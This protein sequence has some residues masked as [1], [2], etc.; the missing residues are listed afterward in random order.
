MHIFNSYK[1]RWLAFIL[2]FNTHKI[3]TLNT[4]LSFFNKLSQQKKKKRHNKNDRKIKTK[5]KLKNP[6]YLKLQ[7]IKGKIMIKKT[8]LWLKITIFAI[9]AITP[10][11]INTSARSDSQQNQVQ[12]LAARPKREVSTP[13]I[14]KVGLW[15]LAFGTNIVDGIDG[16]NG[17]IFQAQ[18][19]DLYAMGYNTGLQVLKGGKLTDGNEF[20]TA[21]GTNI[22]KGQYGTIFQAQNGDLY[23]MGYGTGLQVLKGGGLTPG[24]AFEKALGTNIIKGQYGTIFQARNGDLYAMGWDTELQVLKGG[25]LTPRKAFEKALG[26]NITKGQYGTIFQA[27]NGDLYAMGY[28]TG[29]EVLKGGKLTGGN[30]FI[31]APGANII[32]G[33]YGTIFQARNGDLYA[34]GWDKGLQVLKGGG[35]TPGKAFEKALGTNITK[36]QHGTIFQ[37]R[38]GDLYAMGWDTEL[39]VLK[40]GGLTPRKAFEKALGTN[41]TKGQYGTIFQARNGDLYAMGLDK[42]LQVL[43]G[44]GALTGGNTFIKAPGTNI[45]KGQYGTIF[46]AQNGNLYAMGNETKLQVLKGG[47]LTGG[48]T[49]IKAPGTN[50]TKGQYGTIF[51]AQ[52]GD[53]YVMRVGIGLQ[54]LKNQLKFIKTDETKADTNDGTIT[55]ANFDNDSS[56]L[57]YRNVDEGTWIDLLPTGIIQGLSPGK[58]QFQW[59]SKNGEHY[60]GTTSE[61]QVISGFQEISVGKNKQQ[62][63]NFAITKF[64]ATINDGL[65]ASETNDDN[66]DQNVIAEKVTSLPSELVGTITADNLG[67]N[68]P[69]SLN[70]VTITYSSPSHD[71][72]TGVI[73]VQAIITSTNDPTIST[74]VYF[75]LSGYQ[76]TRQRAAQNQKAIKDAADWFKGTGEGE[77]HAKDD[78]D[79]IDTSTGVTNKNDILPSE[80]STIN[81]ANLGIENLIGSN[82]N[83]VNV[84]YVIDEGDANDHEGTI[85][86]KAT[87]SKQG[88]TP[89]VVYFKLS[90]YQ[91]TRQ[92][93]AQNQKAIEDTFNIINGALSANYNGSILEAITDWALFSSKT[94]D[95]DTSTIPEGVVIKYKHPIINKD[96][97]FVISFHISKGLVNKE[98]TKKINATIKDE[99][100]NAIILGI[101][102]PIGIIF[103][104]GASYLIFK[105]MKKK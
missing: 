5:L 77:F 84:V 59:K 56:K 54:V 47:A 27:R 58:Y 10:V 90:G 61:T 14:P 20:V 48:N 78:K 83:N 6:Y 92:R 18:N 72:A 62:W 4:M 25:G 15:N 51:Q 99:S 30:T 65:K 28:N 36:G 44:G 11:L 57:Q 8:L 104:A 82:A 31:K 63:V 19:G 50:I 39:Q 96:G 103:L 79:N 22:I 3:H 41:I 42:G 23:A 81:I 37:A 75:K 91:T 34:M 12:N 7:F 60:V 32:R 105:K 86:V 53:L 21:P 13:T 95:I 45:T 101:T 66:L 1:R 9:F 97:V 88:A 24:K 33:K 55:I 69:S 26:T 87:I 40:G 94:F 64:K 68:E 43:K 100:N 16:I 2:E 80:I 93:A 29:L 74:T 38:N 35:L 85:I 89:Q 52:N 46:Q 70:Y 98:F 49:F 71:D 67:F 102:I 76:T 73:V 17:T